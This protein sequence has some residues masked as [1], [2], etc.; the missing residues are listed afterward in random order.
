MTSYNSN[1]CTYLAPAY[2]SVLNLYK[3]SLL[4]HEAPHWSFY[5]HSHIPNLLS[6]SFHT[7][8]TLCPRFL[9]H[10]FLG[11]PISY[12]S[13]LQLNIISSRLPF[14]ICLPNVAHPTPFPSHS[15]SQGLVNIFYKGPLCKC[16]NLCRPDGLCHKDPRHLS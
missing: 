14:L 12:P 6:Q 4:P 10:P 3:L 1:K 8:S 16:P 11:L 5:F 9:P 7:C 2:L 13:D 15:L